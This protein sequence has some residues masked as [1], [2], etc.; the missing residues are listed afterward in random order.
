MAA[1]LFFCAASPALAAEAKK[2]LDPS[3]SRLGAV[4]AGGVL[5]L[6]TQP[7]RDVTASFAALVSAPLGYPK[8]KR[9]AEFTALSASLPRQVRELNGRLASD[10]PMLVSLCAQPDWDSKS[11]L[12]AVLQGRERVWSLTFTA[13]TNVFGVPA[14]ATHPPNFFFAGLEPLKV[15]AVERVAAAQGTCTKVKRDAAG[16]VF[17]EGEAAP[18]KFEASLPTPLPAGSDH[19]LDFADDPDGAVAGLMPAETFANLHR[20]LPRPRAAGVLSLALSGRSGL[21]SGPL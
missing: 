7:K 20:E 18:V 19:L 2:P 9:A 10:G 1:L 12:E 14:S 16:E 15:T 13:D 5:D 4:F 11:K 3:V 17:F 8:E 21:C 6:I